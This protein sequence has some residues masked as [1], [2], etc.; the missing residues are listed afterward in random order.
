MNNSLGPRVESAIEARKSMVNDFFGGW[1]EEDIALLSEFSAHTEYE[2]PPDG[3]I[4]DWLGVKTKLEHHAWLPRPDG[5]K[6]VL[7]ASLPIPDDQ[8]HAEAIE[9][10]ALCIA[11]KRA[12]S[13]GE[14]HF[15]SVELGSSYGPWTIASGVL[16]LRMGFDH[17]TLIPVEASA[18]SFNKLFEHA[19]AND[20]LNNTRLSFLPRNIAVGNKPGIVFFPLVDTSVD[21]GA[22]I[23]ESSCTTDYRGLEVASQ[24]V[25]AETITMIAGN[26]DHV[27]FLHVDLQ[28]A[29]EAIIQSQEF[30]D[31]L[32]AKVSVFYL[33]TQSR[34]IEGIA[35]KTLPPLG[36][37]LLR[38]R[39]TKYEQNSRTQDV[40]GWTTRDGGQT[41]I[42]PSFS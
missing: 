7:V 13:R 33:A 14:T 9:Y 24:P 6:G 32:Q 22:Q 28:G 11:I 12:Q 30:K 19:Q 1:N 41:W 34:F 17:V 21:N 16:G 39:P 23:S 40:N 36:F 2:I 26:I 18:E 3:Y 15:T 38:E 31:F 29:E 8:V 37:Q 20:L 42:N 4:L 27:D 10:L 35:L 25:A 5:N